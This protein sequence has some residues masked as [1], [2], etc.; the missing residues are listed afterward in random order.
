MKR[1]DEESN[2]EWRLFPEHCWFEQAKVVTIRE[3]TSAY[4]CVSACGFIDKLA[5]EGHHR[6]VVDLSE[7]A[8][9]PGAFMGFLQS[10]CRRH[11]QKGRR[12]I[13][14]GSGK[15]N[16]ERIETNKP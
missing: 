6:I 8:K 1:F 9:V 10:L 16:A 7:V 3:L 11:S 5:E 14:V 13:I 2:A 4:D 12:I 15:E